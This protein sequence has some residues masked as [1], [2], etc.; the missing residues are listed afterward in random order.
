MINKSQSTDFK[1]YFSE[2]MASQYEKRHLGIL[3]NDAV[4]CH[5]AMTSQQQLP[6]QK[7]VTLV[8]LYL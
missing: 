1:S 4:L 8:T 7:S 5:Q 3:R 2:E 6:L